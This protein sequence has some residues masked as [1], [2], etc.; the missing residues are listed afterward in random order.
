MFL[1]A[2]NEVK[3]GLEV[4]ADINDTADESCMETQVDCQLLSA[5]ATHFLLFCL[6]ATNPGK[7][8][9]YSATQCLRKYQSE[10]LA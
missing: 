3:Q 1:Q 5:A 10:V 2:V 7:A 9:K 6:Q 4:D 8:Y